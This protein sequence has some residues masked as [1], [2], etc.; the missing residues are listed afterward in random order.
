MDTHL[1]QNEIDRLFR[2]PGEEPARPVRPPQNDL[3]EL[4]VG[5]VISLDVPAG[6]FADLVNALPKLQGEVV[7]AGSRRCVVIAPAGPATISIVCAKSRCSLA[8]SFGRTHLTLEEVLNLSSGAIVEL[9]RSVSD[10][11]DVLVNDAVRFLVRIR[12]SLLQ[13]N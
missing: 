8:L 5:D 7:A 2:E 12:Q 6:R 10:P 11:V 13:G 1:S 9:N 3:L 4:A